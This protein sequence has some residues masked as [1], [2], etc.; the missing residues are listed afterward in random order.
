MLFL[1]GGWEV[2]MDSYETL[3]TL[4]LVMLLMLML[5]LVVLRFFHMC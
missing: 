5:V 1:E 3:R 2:P 4:L